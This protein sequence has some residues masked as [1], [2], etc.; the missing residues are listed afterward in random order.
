MICIFI[1]LSHEELPL[2]RSRFHILFLPVLS[3]LHETTILEI[4]RLP[5]RD[6]ADA[7]ASAEPVLRMPMV[8]TQSTSCLLSPVLSAQCVSGCLILA[9]TALP[10]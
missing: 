10:S 8:L 1:V 2:G 5:E 9:I 3:L 7:G 6:A 4:R